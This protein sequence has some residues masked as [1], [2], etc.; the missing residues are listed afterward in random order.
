MRVLIVKLSSLGDVIHTLPALT[1]LRRHWPDAHLTWL[2]EPAAAELLDGHPALNRVLILPRPAWRNLWRWGQGRDAARALRDFL[3]RLRDTPYDLI[4]DF[5]GLAKSAVWVAAARGACKL[6]PG[7]GRRRNELAWLAY[8]RR[9]PLADPGAHAI[10]RSL[11]LL[12]ALGLARLPI[13]YDVPIRPENEREAAE[14]LTG[15][16]L[17]Q[18][19]PFVAVNPQTRWRTKNWTAAGF[20]AVADR[21]AERGLPVVFTG[22]PGD[23]AALDEIAAA[24]HSPMRRLDGQTTLKT[25]AALYRRARVVLSTDTGPMHLAVAVGT[26]V[27]ALFGPTD[28]RSTGPYGA[29]HVVLR[30]GVPCSPCFQKT[31]RTHRVETHA[32]MR[33]LAPDAVADTVARLAQGEHP[34]TA[35]RPLPA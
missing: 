6:G 13:R 10:E 15:L 29:G 27:V 28:P 8:H 30:C 9:A 14:R 32:C 34:A 2:V 20:A 12:D 4:L 17:G 35:P 3:Q 26:P 16:G 25:L 21:L 22:A 33:R 23:R 19:A 18:G 11:A 5:Q 31:C 1:A 7:P 24:M